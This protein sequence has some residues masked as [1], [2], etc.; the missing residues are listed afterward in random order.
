MPRRFSGAALL[1]ALSAYSDTMERKV[2][3]AFFDAIKQFSSTGDLP[4][5]MRQLQQGQ[6]VP[7]DLPARIEQL[8]MNTDEIARLVQRRQLSGRSQL[9]IGRIG[10]LA[11]RR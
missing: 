11:R 3:R 2:R 4:T 5:M 9:Q 10:E 6:I 8:S 1:Q 7:D